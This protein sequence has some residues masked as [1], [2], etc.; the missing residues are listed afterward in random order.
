MLSKKTIVDGRYE[1][2][3]PYDRFAEPVEAG[4]VTLNPAEMDCGAPAVFTLTYTVGSGG[5]AVGGSFQIEIPWVSMQSED[6]AAAGYVS[7]STDGDA[8]LHLVH[9]GWPRVFI[10]TPD[11]VKVDAYWAC[12]VVRS[13][14]LDAGDKIVFRLGRPECPATAPQILSHFEDPSRRVWC[15]LDAQGS[16]R[17]R[18]L[19]NSPVLTLRPGKPARLRIALSA[20]GT[21]DTSMLR[22]AVLDRNDHFLYAPEPT[23]LTLYETQET[24]CL[25]GGGRDSSS[26]LTLLSAREEDAAGMRAVCPAAGVGSDRYGLY[27][28]DIHFH[29]NFSNDVMTKAGQ[30]TPEDSYR[31]A[32]DASL[33]DFAVLTDH[34]EPVL[35]TWIPMLERGIGM[36]PQ[37]WEQSKQISDS[38]NETGRFV[39]FFGY[40]Y[41]TMRGDTNVYFKDPDAPL[42]PGQL[43]S[44]SRIREYCGGRTF[45]SAPHLHP[46]SHNVLTLGAWKW[47][48]S[49]QSC[50]DEAGG[51]FEP[52]IE[53]CSG[54]G[55]FEYY[56][57]RPGFPRRGMTEGNSVQAHLLR[58]IRCGVYGGS[59]DH[60]GRPG[61]NGLMALYAE[62]LSREHIFEA[63]RERRC[64]ATTNA[65]IVLRFSV[66]GAFMGSEIVSD[67]PVTIETAAVG[68]D[69]IVSVEILRDARV[70][71]RLN[72]Q[73]QSVQLSWTDTQPALGTSWYYVR[74]RQKDGQMA[75]SSPVWV[76]SRHRIE[77]MHGDLSDFT[78]P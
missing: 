13:G 40:E 62:S 48:Q 3:E 78:T 55:R 17:C 37:H 58:G 7:V 47:N 53:M 72:P 41:R 25:P 45:F 15:F 65:R 67:D 61:R 38:F 2:G 1:Y 70:V 30:N 66:N 68:M 6:P 27:W 44:F 71:H 50:W 51:A 59:D 46:Y 52:I 42:L 19:T 28:G 34:Y 63:I 10:T 75:W 54:H 49:V 12:A 29:S 76:T 21:V 60:T 26:T 73:A 5:I 4:T 18:K 16:G 33:L 69:T 23:D 8:V 24:A 22:A 11:E 43:D 56:G 31:Y 74:I 77:D 32:R 20:K 35:R 64:Y 14:V 36:T 9:K 57:N 39:T